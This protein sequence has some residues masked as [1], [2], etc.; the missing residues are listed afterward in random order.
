MGDKVEKAKLFMAAVDSDGVVTRMWKSSRGNF[1]GTDLP[2]KGPHYGWDI[3]K[4]FLDKGVE[5][6]QFVE[7][8]AVSPNQR[9]DDKDRNT[10]DTGSPHLVKLDVGYWGAYHRELEAT[11]DNKDR[12]FGV[13]CEGD[14]YLCRYVGLGSRAPERELDPKPPKLFQDFLDLTK[15]ED[16]GQIEIKTHARVPG[17]PIDGLWFFFPDM[18]LTE[19]FPERPLDSER[20]TGGMAFSQDGNLD[21]TKA[22]NQLRWRLY[23]VQHK[24]GTQKDE[25]F[26]KD[27]RDRMVKYLDSI[28]SASTDLAKGPKF[29]FGV[30]LSWEFVSAGD[31]MV[32]MVPG[33]IKT[34]EFTPG[35][36]LAEKA[37]ID[38]EVCLNAAWFYQPGPAVLPDDQSSNRK[39]VIQRE[40]DRPPSGRNG[41]GD[42]DPQ[43][44]VDLL[45]MLMLVK[46]H[47]DANAGKVH[48]VQVGDL[49]ELWM[50]R[51]FLYRY[52]PVLDPEAGSKFKLWAAK[53]TSVSGDG[54]QDRIGA[55]LAQQV[56]AAPATRTELRERPAK[57]F[58]FEE[59]TSDD[60][61][62]R[63]DLTG[64]PSGG[65]TLASV[66]ADLADR[67]KAVRDFSIRFPGA[68]A[69]R[70]MLDKNFG[71]KKYR[72]TNR[73][74]HM[75]F[76]YNLAILD[77]F[78][79]LEA[80]RIYG[81]HDGYRGDSKLNAKL[82]DEDKAEAWISEKGF[83]VEHSHRW[84]DFNRDGM[85]FGAGITN[86]VHYYA[87]AML[88]A[89]SMFS[90]LLS[91]EEKSF[92]PGAAQWFVIVHFAK[93]K[94][95]A[96]KVKPFNVYVSGHTHSP[97]LIGIRLE[98]TAAAGAKAAAEDAK[99]SFKKAV[100]SFTFEVARFN[101]PM[102]WINA[103][104][105]R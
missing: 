16:R 33:E 60:L 79:K 77:M 12:W 48:V 9:S 18:H 69:D 25:T 2:L 22:R 55:M 66:Q 68:T 14:V 104:G 89:D 20:Y 70:Q 87:D 57:S 54:T 103:M 1:W 36:F 90:G 59:W 92:Q 53:C 32:V 91:Q 93:S 42:G 100:D 47:R 46:K 15:K 94:P 82:A 88:K 102:S 38:R 30:V 13:I 21:Q 28:S 19:R 56:G 78:K 41:D 62:K 86:M 4:D 97:T 43:T 81:N 51:S 67:V 23:D 17:D 63:L 5:R 85:A 84:D 6:V 105:V 44:A 40:R 71:D 98:L 39:D 34:V 29:K 64:S 37:I 95:D 80:R 58:A 7:K 11:S 74:G 35:E 45:N 61:V 96:N 76:L 31:G 72:R 10:L 26:T 27:D 65:A 75:E 3:Q 83:W 52:Y 101:N 73:R 24:P 8:A 49:Y 99:A 50:N